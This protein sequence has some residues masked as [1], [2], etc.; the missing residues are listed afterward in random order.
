[1]ETKSNIML[2]AFNSLVEIIII[3]LKLN[4][5]SPIHAGLSSELH[6]H[7]IILLEHLQRDYNVINKETTE[8]NLVF[9][10]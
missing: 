1:M 3:I 10:C 6:L 4:R 2:K 7:I 9:F 8:L 5:S